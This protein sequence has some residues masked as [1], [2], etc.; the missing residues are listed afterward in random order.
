MGIW[1]LVSDQGST[2]IKKE[3]KQY[4]KD[5]GIE[6]NLVAKGNHKANGQAERLVRQVHDAINRLANGKFNHWHELL[7]IVEFNIRTAPHSVTGIIPAMELYGRELR[8]GVL[9][10]PVH[11]DTALDDRRFSQKQKAAQQALKA[12]S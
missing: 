12:I 9:E 10:V 2:Y 8:K 11:S 6:Q 3:F 4:A 7:P 1:T 5:R